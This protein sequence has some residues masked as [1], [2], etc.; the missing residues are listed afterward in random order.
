[1]F[2]VPSPWVA[3]EPSLCASSRFAL[4]S[5]GIPI[6]LVVTSA[7]PSQLVAGWSAF[8]SLLTPWFRSAADWGTSRA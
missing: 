3:P 1:M 5:S 6:A 4:P 8:S 2:W 7:I